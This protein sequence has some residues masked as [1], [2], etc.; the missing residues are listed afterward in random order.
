M[1]VFN[2][3]LSL[4]IAEQFPEFVRMDQAGVIPF[5]EKYYEFLESAELIVERVGDIDHILLEQGAE[6][7]LV[8]ENSQVKTD[9]PIDY[10]V[11]EESGIGAFENGEIITGSTSGKTATIRVED[12]NGSSTLYIS[13]QTGFLIGER[14][15]GGSSLAIAYIKSYRSNPVENVSQ[16]MEYASVDETVDSF[17]D[18]FKKQ[19]LR[20]IPKSLASGVHKRNLLKN[21]TDLYRAKGS[22]KGHELFFRVLLDET[23][24]LFYP[25]EHVLRV[26]D[27]NWGSNIIL[28]V[29]QDQS[30]MLLEDLTSTGNIN[31]LNENGSH[32]LTEDNLIGDSDLQKLVGQIVTQVEVFDTSIELGGSYYGDGFDSIT[33]A[34][35]Q[36]ESV[37]QFQLGSELVTELVLNSNSISGTFVVGQDITSPDPDNEDVNLTGKII[38]ILTGFNIASSS[39]YFST[40]DSLT[41][42]ASNGDNGRIGI[43]QLTKGTINEIIVGEIGSG[44]EIGE[45]VVV[46]NSN[47]NGT[48]LSAKI[49]VVNGGIAPELGD[50]SAEFNFI[51]ED[52]GTDGAG[53]NAG[54]DLL[55]EDVAVTYFTQEENYRMAEEDHIVLEDYT[56]WLDGSSGNKIVQEAYKWQGGS[57]VASDGDITDIVVI[58][59]GRGY[60]SVPLL[61]I[62]TASGT[63]GKIFAKGTNVGKIKDINIFD[64]GIHYTGTSE[65][66]SKNHYLI[67]NITGEFSTDE[68]IVGGTSGATGVLKSVD[69]DR[70]IL[71]ILSTAD[72]F[73]AGETITA[74]GGA[75]AIID[76]FTPTSITATIGATANTFGRYVNQDGWLSEKTKR[77]QDSFYYQDFS[78]VVKTASSII[79]WR[80]DVINAVHPA[81]FALFG[82][83]S[84]TTLVN[85]E[86]RIADRLPELIDARDT[87]TPELFSLLTTIFSA[88]FGRRLGTTDQGNVN[89]NPELGIEL[90][91]TFNGGRDVTL[92]HYM[93]VDAY[94]TPTNHLASDNQGI[95]SML[96]NVEKYKFANS[97]LDSNNSSTTFRSHDGYNETRNA[98][99]YFVVTGETVSG[100][101]IQD[102]ADVTIGDVTNYPKRK[103]NITPPTEITLTI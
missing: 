39:Q 66:V 15:T 75:T 34:T 99:T 78:Y 101:R 90:D 62:T 9:P 12:I 51:I 40:T 35:A 80:N 19:Y 97:I 100:Y 89:T 60:S 43:D 57:A 46:D 10:Q 54:D 20:T 102:W 74:S 103:H 86:V 4:K 79:N 73:I 76:S 95:G 6:N 11:M 29:I 44:Y 65:V 85:A 42:T 24:D 45:V 26:S 23:A 13:S 83:I 92:D 64:H 59:P 33:K 67:K 30:T 91:E 88:K 84:S 48:G 14:I 21:I 41:I 3:K 63:N 18:E 38:S 82:E 96:E 7:K 32:F 25:T 93:T 49:S 70:Y 22:R 53:A 5:L 81:G 71:K 61:T 68:T 28:R 16:L 2:K 69:T 37:T 1:S 72:S 47:T 56:V 17:F 50:L 98:T 58:N 55:T 52:G 8:Y 87:Y 27:G 77:I 31:I 36:V 94:I